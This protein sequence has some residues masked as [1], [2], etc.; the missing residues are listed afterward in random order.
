MNNQISIEDKFKY[1]RNACYLLDDNAERQELLLDAL[2]ILDKFRDNN[3]VIAVFAP[4]NYGKS[5]LLNA[6][7]SL[8]RDKN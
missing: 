1:I 5:T 6:L 4:F 3:F 8:K 2:A 7:L